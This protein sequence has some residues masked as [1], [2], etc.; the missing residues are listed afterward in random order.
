L[1][2]ALW[3][4]RCQGLVSLISYNIQNIA[5]AKE[6]GLPTREHLLWCQ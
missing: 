5:R 3:P 2:A 4:Q 6:S 1:V